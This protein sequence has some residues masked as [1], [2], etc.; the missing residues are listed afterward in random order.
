M[1]S[2]LSLVMIGGK[3]NSMSNKLTDIKSCFPYLVDEERQGTSRS[4]VLY[5]QL[6]HS[7]ECLSD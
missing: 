3:T 5:P 4:P 1:R 6:T 2:Q 7:D